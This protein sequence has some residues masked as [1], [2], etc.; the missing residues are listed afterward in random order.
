MT[1]RGREDRAGSRIASAT[2]E[3]ASGGK[4]IFWRCLKAAAE[5]WRAAKALRRRAP[6]WQTGYLIDKLSPRVAGEEQKRVRCPLLFPVLRL[7]IKPSNGEVGPDFWGRSLGS[8][9]R[10]VPE[11]HLLARIAAGAPVRSC[12]KITPISGASSFTERYSSPVWRATRF[13]PRRFRS[14]S[15]G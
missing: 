5:N 7:T 6:S 2:A 9:V 8:S 1:P 15:C 14:R 4:P 3:A 13:Q 10:I 12:Q 11:D